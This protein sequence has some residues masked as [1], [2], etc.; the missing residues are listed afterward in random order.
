MKRIKENQSEQG[1]LF[2]NHYV[3]DRLCWGDEVFL[4]KALL[5]KLDIGSITGSY[6]SEGGKMFSPQDHLSVLLYAFYKGITSSV[7]MS[8][9]VRTDLR[10]IYLAGGHIIKRRI[11]CDFRIRHREEIRKLFESLISLA[12]DA[13]IV[14]TNSLFALD[15]SK[16][17]AQASFSKKRKKSEW[18]KR[19]KEIVEHV[20][21][22]LREWEERDELKEDIEER[23]KKEFEKIRKRLDV[24]KDGQY[25]CKEE[26][27]AEGSGDNDKGTSSLDDKEDVSF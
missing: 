7:K 22:Y 15:G 10:F 13:G 4:F 11:I 6:S 1:I 24:I 25:R 5:E 14:R 8:E 17:E 27:Y 20:D 12:V 18:I 2:P 3:G 9:L 23:K 26:T 16:I 19:Q 21:R